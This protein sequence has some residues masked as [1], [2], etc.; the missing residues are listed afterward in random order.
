MNFLKNNPFRAAKFEFSTPNLSDIPP[1]QGYEVAFVG[2]SNAG[3]SSALNVLC[4]HKSLA[5]VSKTPG[6]TQHLVFFRIDSTRFFVDLPGYG[7]AKVALK[8]REQWQKTLD[9]YLTSRDALKGV[10]LMMDTR[11]PLKEFDAKMIEWCDYAKM[12][13]LILL[14]KSD[15]LKKGP[16]NAALHK[17]QRHIEEMPDCRAQLFSASKK[18]GLESARAHIA[19]WM[20]ID[21]SQEDVVE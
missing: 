12:P 13:L 5:R 2:R 17:V 16:A 10:V 7:Y 19:S 11:H 1:D 4:D 3:K 21:D 8:V 6:R 9:K 20:M 18:V 14:T 15:K